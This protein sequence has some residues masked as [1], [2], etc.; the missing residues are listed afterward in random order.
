MHSSGRNIAHHVPETDLRSDYA[1]VPG[2]EFPKAVYRSVVGAFAA[3]VVVAWLTFGGGSDAD[4]TLAFASVLTV[5]L[6]ALPILVRRTAAARS[7]DKPESLDAFLGSRVDTATG[8]L[9]GGEAWLQILI[10]PL[11]LAMAA[12][13]IGAVFLLVA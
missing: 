9:A 11:T 6:F 8:L 3:V 4:L 13:L 7:T 12:V 10:I 2:A 1:H 5:V